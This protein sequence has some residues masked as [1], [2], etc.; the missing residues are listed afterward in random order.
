MKKE[1]RNALENSPVIVA[2]KDDEGLKTCLTSESQ[3]VFILYGDI[4]TIP[5]I[6]QTVKASGKLAMVHIDLITGLSNKEVAVDFLKKH[7]LADGIIT[8]KPNL[9]K[10]AKEIGFYTILRFFL[11]DSMAYENIER[12]VKL[13]KPDVIEVLPAMAKIVS[14]VCVISPTP[15]IAGGLVSDKE[16]VMT[17][18][19]AGVI[20]VSTTTKSLWFI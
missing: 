11:I 19:Q 8:T 14:K 13:T 16:D 17:L 18:L 3:V 2:I 6:V 20:S 10:H 15:V 1:F 12:Q 4:I 7:T 9:I 5:D